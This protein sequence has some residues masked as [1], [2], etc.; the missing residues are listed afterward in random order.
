MEANLWVG[1]A[2]IIKYWVDCGRK[3]HVKLGS[4]IWWASAQDL[5]FQDKHS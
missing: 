3:I 5:N 2:D 4:L 1:L